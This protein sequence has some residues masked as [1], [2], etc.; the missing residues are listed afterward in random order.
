M[1]AMTFQT[2]QE[3]SILVEYCSAPP[4]TIML[5]SN[6]TMDRMNKGT[7]TGQEIDMFHFGS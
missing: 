7:G 5:M 2:T 1:T 4:I 6:V 3:T